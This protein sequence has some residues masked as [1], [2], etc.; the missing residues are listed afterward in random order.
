MWTGTFYI[1]HSCMIES[2]CDYSVALIRL[3]KWLPKTVITLTR[4]FARVEAQ[5]HVPP[6]LSKATKSQLSPLE[7]IPMDLL[8]FLQTTFTLTQK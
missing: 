7:M 8:P 6:W 2:V 1:T 3:G 4:N 5:K